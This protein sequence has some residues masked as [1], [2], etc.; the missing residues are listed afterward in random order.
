MDTKLKE[1]LNNENVARTYL[2]YATEPNEVDKAIRQL[3]NAR[4]LTRAY[5]VFKKKESE[6]EY[7]SK[8][9]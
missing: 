3:D 2:E 5:I 1:L 6:Y 9:S 4:A 8:N 7:I